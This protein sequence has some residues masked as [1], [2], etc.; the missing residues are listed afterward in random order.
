MMYQPCDVTYGWTVV[1]EDGTEY[2]FSAGRNQ[3]M[4]EAYFEIDKAVACWYHD[5][6]GYHYYILSK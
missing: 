3:G 5:E 6:N 4:A 1:I 2:H